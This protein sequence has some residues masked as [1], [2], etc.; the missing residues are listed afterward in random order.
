MA[1]YLVELWIP[2]EGMEGKCLEISS[3]VLDY[4][5]RNRKEFK[6]LKSLRLLRI[7]IGSKPW[8]VTV[9]EYDDLK[10]MEELDKRIVN[11]KEYIGLIMEWKKCIE[12]KESNALLLMGLLRDKWIED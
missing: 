8:W 7:F 10:P 2:K 5:R 4:V 11:D 3:K 12:Y 6:E 1:I 9:Q